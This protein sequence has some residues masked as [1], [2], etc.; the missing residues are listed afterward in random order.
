MSKSKISSAKIAKNLSFTGY[1]SGDLFY[2]GEIIGRYIK[3]P[4]SKQFLTL[5][6]HPVHIEVGGRTQKGLLNNLAKEMAAAINQG[7]WPIDDLESYGGTAAA[8]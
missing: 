1:A 6:Y 7:K 2:C 3:D 4:A 8:V 5:I